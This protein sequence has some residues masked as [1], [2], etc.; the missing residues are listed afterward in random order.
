MAKFIINGGNKIYGKVKNE[1]AK[2]A[3]LPLLAAAI[4]CEQKVTILDCPDILDVK[5]LVEILEYINVKCEINNNNI[6][7]DAS[8]IILRPIP[9]SLTSKLR[10]SIFLLGSLLAKL[11][12]VK[13]AFPGGCNIG[14][15]PI[16][17]HISALRKIGV[18][19]K[20]GCCEIECKKKRFL[21]GEVV[22][23]F[24]SVGATENI[25]MCSTLSNKTTTIY[26]AAREP[27]IVDLANFINAC[28]G[29]IYGQGTK[30]IVIK[31]VKKLKGVT[32][33]PI[34]DRIEL[35]TFALALANV[36]GELEI[37]GADMQNILPLRDKF[38]D[39]ACKITANNDIIHI[40]CN[41][42]TNP[43]SITTGPY[44]MFPTDLQ[45]Q[46]MSTNC[47][48]KG[49]SL[50]REKVFENRFSHADEF[51]KMG[52]DISIKNDVAIVR[53]VKKLHGAKVVAKD[54]RGGA[55]LVI[56]S[57]GA[58]GTTEIDDVFHIDRGYANLVQKLKG[59]G[60]DIK[61]V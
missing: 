42:L 9:L 37:Y 22:L 11:G 21:G 15:R 20:V 27:E 49:L 55:A 30:K 34:S 54:L 7:V 39:N 10:S 23:P 6:T 47:T 35:G 53:G 40:S 36:G 26:N 16:D 33:K 12:E 51:V 44:P 18:E 52:A 61:R 58:E 41:R 59:V 31:G 32:Y 3:V 43:M 5:I 2:N 56:A 19:C 29:K 48:A 28:G 57:L 14:A 1:S 8:N 50:I 38:C 13:L 24:A 60:V 25:I 17:I 45:A 4:M 46:L